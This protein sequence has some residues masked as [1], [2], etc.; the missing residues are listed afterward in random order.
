MVAYFHHYFFGLS[1][2][3]LSLI[4]LVFR[5]LVKPYLF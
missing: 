1:L 5:L 4:F 3:K 2:L